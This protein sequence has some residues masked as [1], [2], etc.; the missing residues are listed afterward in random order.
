MPPHALT[1]RVQSRQEFSPRR[2]RPRTPRARPRARALRPAAIAFLLVLRGRVRSCVFLGMP[3]FFDYLPLCVLCFA[4][5]GEIGHFDYSRSFSAS[6]SRTCHVTFFTPAQAP[7]RSRQKEKKKRPLLCCPRA[8]TRR[9]TFCTQWYS[10]AGSGGDVDDILRHGG[11]VLAGDGADS[12][13]AQAGQPLDRRR[14][15]LAATAAAATPGGA[16]RS[17]TGTGRT[18][19]AVARKRARKAANRHAKKLL[20]HTP[21]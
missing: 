16:G 17:G 13:G 5:R 7:K 8:G 19:Q 14:S 1:S 12:G 15:A 20:S 10:K 11:P 4:A 3:C 6:W 9:R 18:P 21:P 2:P